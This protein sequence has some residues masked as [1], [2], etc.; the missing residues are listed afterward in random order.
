MTQAHFDHLSSIYL[1]D[2]CSKHRS[3]GYRTSDSS[4]FVNSHGIASNICMSKAC[5]ELCTSHVDPFCQMLMAK[6]AM[7]EI[8]FEIFR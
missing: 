6:G 4:I 2:E 7:V 3:T 1:R 5:P 8:S